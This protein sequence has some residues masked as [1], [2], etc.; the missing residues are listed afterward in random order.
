LSADL[1]SLLLAAPFVF[2]AY[3]VFGITGF[4]ATIVAMPFLV[5]FEPLSFAVPMMLLLDVLATCTIGSRN[6]RDV[7]RRELVLL[8]PAMLL[9]I[10]AGAAALRHLQSDVLLLCLAVFIIANSLWGLLSSGDAARRI[11]RAWAVPAGLVGGGFGAAFGTGGPVYTIFLMRRIGDVI[12]LRAT[13]AIVILASALMRTAVFGVSGL[14]SNPRVLWAA[15]LLAPMCLLGLF[16]GSKLRMRVAPERIRK[17]ILG[18]LL[19][20]GVAVLVRVLKS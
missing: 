19:A 6:W 7:E 16:V 13:I 12:T 5:Q 3:I 8:L 18:L 9:G 1:V 20:A 2:G 11:H 4:G 17:V 10:V 15:A 14:L